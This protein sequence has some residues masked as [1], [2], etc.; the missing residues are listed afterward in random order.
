MP[1]N[2][3]NTRSFYQ[4]TFAG[5]GTLETIT[6]LKRGDNQ[7]Q[8]TVTAYVLFNCRRSRIHK[9]GTTIQETMTY[10]NWAVWHVSRCELDQAGVPY[11]TKLDRIV[12]SEGR[13]WQP[14]TPEDLDIKLFENQIDIPCQR[15]DPPK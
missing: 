6:L 8:G 1:L 3:D 11:L 13:H 15:V 4:K 2:R 14:E 9:A 5:S 10:R 7:Q 12:D